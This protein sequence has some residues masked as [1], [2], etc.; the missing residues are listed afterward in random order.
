MDLNEK[1]IKKKVLLDE[2]VIKR[3]S[4]YKVEKIIIIPGKIINIVF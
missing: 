3:I 1:D 4:G 2:R